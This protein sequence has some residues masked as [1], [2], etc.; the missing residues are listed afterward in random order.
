MCSFS[1]V[2]HSPVRW[3]LVIALALSMSMSAA[4]TSH[5][6][7]TAAVSLAKYNTDRAYRQSVLKSLQPLNDK[8]TDPGLVSKL[9]GLLSSKSIE[10]QHLPR[11]LEL[12]SRYKV[13]GG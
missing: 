2:R 12:V 8:P 11:L 13:C 3:I 1:E 9:N 5:A 6:A 4:S 10:Q 7:P